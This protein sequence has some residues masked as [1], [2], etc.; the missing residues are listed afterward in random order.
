MPTGFLGLLLA[1]NLVKPL[2]SL[3]GTEWRDRGYGLREDTKAETIA[4]SR[5]QKAQTKC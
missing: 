2:I 3:Y 1:G 5:K 4:E